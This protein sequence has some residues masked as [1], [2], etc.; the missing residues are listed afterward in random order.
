MALT[1]REE[2]K[3]EIG[4]LK[5]LLN[6][7]EKQLADKDLEISRLNDILASMRRRLFGPRSE[8][9]KV[10][11][12]DSQQMSLFN[13]AELEGTVDFTQDEADTASIVKGH[14][15]K[16]SAPK[17]LELAGMES[18]TIVHDITE[19]DRIC[20][21]CGSSNL[22]CIGEELVRYELH[23]VPASY[24]VKKH[25]QKIYKCL[26]C[27]D[28]E[29]TTILKSP[30][31]NPLIPHS[32]VTASSMTMTILN[33][34]QFALPF[35]RQEKLWRMMGIKISK[36]TMSNWIL[37]AYRDWLK[38]MLE[39]MQKQLL[40]EDVLHADETRVQVMKEKGR[41]NTSQSYMWLY[42]TGRFAEHQ[43]RLFKYQPSRSGDCAAD[44]LK[45]F[46]GFLHTDA[47]PGYNKVEDVIHCF[48]YAHA[49]RKFV[50]S[51]PAGTADAGDTISGIA[52]KRINELFELEEKYS[53]LSVEERQKSRIEEA[54]PKILALFEYLENNLGKI[55][56]SSNLAKAMKYMLANKKSF[57]NYINDF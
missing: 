51:I 41:K 30:V 2:L 40:R 48:C 25:V 28:D 8:R 44:F 17:K 15:R 26:D 7:Q 50:E 16:K 24:V 19:A 36:A 52:I 37:Y 31:P 27:S 20:Q 35:S 49:R 11:L 43:I 5:S 22:T 38:P 18:E 32:P 45:G 54:K 13:E 33:K 53:A 3:K 6:K 21:D 57:M 10:V 39:V 56:Q 14:T 47:Y 1:E 55:P 23:V 12:P 42:T 4:R 34:F 29:H 46:H 9:T